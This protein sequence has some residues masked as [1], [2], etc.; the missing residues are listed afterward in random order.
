MLVLSRKVGEKIILGDNIVVT[1]VEVK[2]N[3]V[4][5][6]LDAPAEVRILRSELAPVTKKT[7]PLDRDPILAQKPVEWTE[8]QTELVLSLSSSPKD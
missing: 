2:G 8:I 1:V 4:R 6:A 5:I 3:R 7:D